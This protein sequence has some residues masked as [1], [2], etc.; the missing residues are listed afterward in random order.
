VVQVDAA[1]EEPSAPA[2][3]QAIVARVGPYSISGATF[4]RMAA[5]ELSTQAPSEQLVAPAFSACV[6]HLQTQAAANDEPAVSVAQLKSECKKR[7]QA[8]LQVALE[9]LIASEWLIGGARELG[10]PVSDVPGLQARA[11]L[12]AAAIRRAIK[13][14]V[15]PVGHAQIER[16]YQQHRFEYLLTGERDLKIARTKSEATALK[17]K[18]EIEAG[19]SFASVVSRLPVQQPIDSNHGLVEELQPHFY[20]E[21]NL[22][23]AIYVAKPGVL[24]GPVD[25]WFGYFVFEVT[26]VRFERVTPLSK[27][28]ASIR[29]HFLQP[30][31][32]QALSAYSKRWIATWTAQTNCSPGFVVPK[33]RQ[34]SGSPVAP[35]EENPTLN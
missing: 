23:E 24:V 1:S 8:A 35:P 15:A 27:L 21:P 22:N 7:Y 13:A 17:V 4:N 33:C 19:K 28:E 25:T 18:A 2:S 32:E 16:Y 34:F 20:G 5:I 30:L 11:R 9:H 10:V 6:A 14:R 31:E 12:A 3:P 29:Q 26:K